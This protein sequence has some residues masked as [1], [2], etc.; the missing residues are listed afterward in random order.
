MFGATVPIG[1]IFLDNVNALFSAFLA[2]TTLFVTVTDLDRFEIPD[3]LSA[4]ILAGGILWS[5]QF[6]GFDAQVLEGTGSRVILASGFLLA[7]RSVFR[8]TRGKEGLGLGDVKLLGAGAAWISWPYIALML[9]VASVAA[10][11]LVVLRSLLLG[12]RIRTDIAIPFGAF[13]APSIW[14]AWL[15]EISS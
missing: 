2:A 10:L 7:L 5:L 6:F 11:A 4:A 13:L 12:E 15:V 14:I 3:A 8:L 1:F 9:L